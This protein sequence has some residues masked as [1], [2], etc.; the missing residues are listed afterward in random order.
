MKSIPKKQIKNQKQIAKIDQQWFKM[1][2]LGAMCLAL[3]MTILNDTV[4]NV[5][6]PHIQISLNATVLGLR[7]ILI[8]YTL[9]IACLVLPSG[10]LG[11][12]YGHKRIFLGGL[13]IFTMASLICNLAPNLTVLIVGRTIQGM[14]AAAIFPGSL[15]ILSDVFPE[16][17]EK[18]KAIALWS[19]VSGLA[20]IAG[21]AF[22][23]L[24]V[25][26]LGWQSIFFLN[27]P[28]GIITFW[29][30][31]LLPKEVKKPMKQ[32]IDVPGIV[33]SIVFLASLASALTQSNAGMGQP[34]LAVILLAFAGLSLI[35]FLL[36]E[37]R[38][39]HPM[40]PLS[41]LRNPTISVVSVTNIFVFYTSY[42]LLFIFSLY[43]QQ[44]QGDSA[45]EAGM[46]F[47]PMN[48][49]YVI[50]AL[51][52]G[53]FAARLGWRLA[54]T[55]GLML[56]CIAVFS[57]ISVGVDTEYG[58]VLWKFMLSGFGTGLTMSP[59]T[60][61]MM[62]SA[63]STKAGIASAILSVTARFGG[64]L[65][66][67]LQGKILSQRITSDLARS[68]SA[69]NLPSNVQERLITNTLRG[70]TKVPNDLPVG[71]SPSVWHQA[72][73]Q[74]FISGVHSAVLIASVALLSGALLVLA[75]VQP[76][77][78]QAAK[79]SPA[80]TGANKK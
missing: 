17:K 24:L 11:D 2:T 8:A 3:F 61:A 33:L 13:V 50:G 71:I 55:T 47:L 48:G 76:N 78:K 30:T 5:A 42:S 6:L 79:N 7:W 16:P 51:V 70:G 56:N 31:S 26:T 9:P 52:S 63:P 27:L 20:L 54:I 41:L 73:N 74:A 80:S 34:S 12:I 77:L 66:I 60:A 15:A 18:T 19:A 28:L 40:L 59:L 64:V 46:R 68:L 57:F 49:A 21:P 45:A 4:I 75:F 1:V 10:M 14:G 65:G 37:T 62:G 44:V 32:P 72:F 43:L 22:G 25:D 29:M 35:A 23:G 67:A 38:S 69:W 36:V 58:D 53:W 39:S